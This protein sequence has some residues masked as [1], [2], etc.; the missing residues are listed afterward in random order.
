MDGGI[1][2]QRL[3]RPALP[4]LMSASLLSLVDLVLNRNE[5][6]CDQ[7]DHPLFI[8]FDKDSGTLI[9]GILILFLAHS[10]VFVF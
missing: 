3:R 1:P 4:K 9:I 2:E 5:V 7:D 6:S 10:I 8:H